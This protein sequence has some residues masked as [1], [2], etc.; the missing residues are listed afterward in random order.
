MAS[1]CALKAPHRSDLP[2]LD[3]T[4]HMQHLVVLTGASRGMGLAM[5]RQLLRPDR[6]LLCIS[7]HTNEAL[8]SESQ[9]LKA[10]LVQWSQD[11]SEPMMAR[12]RLKA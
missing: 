7:R 8:A 4:I 11:L 5:A 6:L 12:Q 1:G 10:P 3:R 2:L 9:R